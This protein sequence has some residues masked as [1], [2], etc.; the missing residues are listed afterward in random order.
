MPNGTPAYAYLAEVMD[1]KNEYRNNKG[2]LFAI[3]AG[4]LVLALIAF[5]GICWGT[6][7]M[8][9][10]WVSNI[11]FSFWELLGI[12]SAG[13]IGILFLRPL[14]RRR[15]APPAEVIPVAVDLPPQEGPS[16]RAM[17]DQLSPEERL[18]FR[19][20]MEKFCADPESPDAINA[21]I[22]PPERGAGA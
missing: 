15:P 3:G 18:A 11:Q 6:L 21:D 14:R 4:A 8:C 16:W 5:S 7:A 2:K 1:W 19:S 17:Y 22:R 20:M 10:S 9:G 13:T 12:S